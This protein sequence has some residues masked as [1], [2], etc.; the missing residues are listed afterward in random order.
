VHPGDDADAVRSGVRVDGELRDF[1]GGLEDRLE[2]DLVRQGAGGVERIDDDLRV[3][4]DFFEVLQ[5]R[6]GP[7]SR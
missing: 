5:T 4:I 7:G 6:R 2:N 1:S 3:F